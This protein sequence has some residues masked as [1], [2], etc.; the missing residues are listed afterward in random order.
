MGVALGKQE[1]EEEMSTQNTLQLI[2]TD[3]INDELSNEFCKRTYLKCK[4]CQKPRTGYS[5]CQSC[6]TKIFEQQFESWTSGNEKLDEMI[7][8]SQKLAR[9]HTDYLEWIPFGDFENDNLQYL[10]DGGYS[11]VIMTNWTKGPKW[12]WDE[13]NQQRIRSGPRKVGGRTKKAPNESTNS[14]DDEFDKAEKIEGSLMHIEDEESSRNVKFS[15]I[16]A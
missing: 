5:W 16:F 4:K 12:S 11:K 14:T 6:E 10:G 3:Q 7:K 9:T 1:I 13:E 15:F 2:S 8:S